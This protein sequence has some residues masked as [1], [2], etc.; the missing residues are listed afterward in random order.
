M[1]KP[2]GWRLADATGAAAAAGVPANRLLAGQL[3]LGAPPLPPLGMDVHDGPRDRAE[4]DASP[5]PQWDHSPKYR[6]TL[7]DFSFR[8][9]R[10]AALAIAGIDTVGHPVTL[11]TSATVQ[12]FLRCSSAAT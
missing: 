4:E 10:P 12:P 1:G 2:L 7:P 9:T 6:V 5:P 8:S 11:S 3:G